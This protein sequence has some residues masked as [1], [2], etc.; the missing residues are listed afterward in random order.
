MVR[1]VTVNFTWWTLFCTRESLLQ[2]G[3]ASF[4]NIL[5]HTH[6]SLQKWFPQ[7]SGPALCLLSSLST[8]Q[9]GSRSMSE[10]A[11]SFFGAQGTEAK[12]SRIYPEANPQPQWGPITRRLIVR[13]LARHRVRS[14]HALGRTRDLDLLPL[15]DEDGSTNILLSGP[16][17]PA[18]AQSYPEQFCCPRLGSWDLPGC[19]PRHAGIGRRWFL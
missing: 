14:T 15:R 1:L 5:S 6:Q 10:T 12:Q 11:T 8:S 17:G 2:E 9:A 7:Y 4:W 13:K 18:L 3:S 19:P 16:L